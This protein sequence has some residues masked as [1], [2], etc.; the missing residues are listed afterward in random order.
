ALARWE[1][2]GPADYELDVA[3]AGN[4]PGRVHVEVRKGEVVKM[5]RDDVEPKQRRTWDV[6]SVPGMFDTIG[7]ELEN[8][9]DPARAFNTPG[10][11]QMVMWADFDRKLGYP[12]RYD[13]VVLGANFETHWR[14]TNFRDLTGP[15]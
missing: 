9:H 5:T 13:R 2:N 11:T 8:A 3:I 6:W 4:R 15:K 1:K 7:Q 12:L 14:V 10:A